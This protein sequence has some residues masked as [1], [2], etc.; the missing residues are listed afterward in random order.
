MKKP[1]YF[2]TSFINAGGMF[3]YV[4]AVSWLIFNGQKLFG[5]RNSFLAPLFF[6]LLFVI[7]AAI[8]GLL[9][10]GRPM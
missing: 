1:N 5:G 10:L 2:L 7:S 9:V 8:T 6:L 3:V 4:Y